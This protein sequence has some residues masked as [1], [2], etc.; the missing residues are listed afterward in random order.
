MLWMQ[1]CLLLWEAAD[2]HLEILKLLTIFCFS[3]AL[4]WP[5]SRLMLL[6][7]TLLISHGGL[8]LTGHTVTTN[9][10]SWRL[11]LLTEQLCSGLRRS[12]HDGR[13]IN[14]RMLKP[15]W[16]EA[17]G[18]VLGM[19][20]RVE[21]M[22]CVCSLEGKRQKPGWWVGATMLLTF[23]RTVSTAETFRCALSCRRQHDGGTII[24]NVFNPQLWLCLCW[25]YLT[26]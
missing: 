4:I 9:S 10:E 1:L 12:C 18:R 8:P 13:Q 26:N 6:T 11:S 19:A 2:Y 3:C 25:P 20:Q 5:L 24:Q 22:R 15:I 14:T 17:V 7:I 16:D 21:S 23:H